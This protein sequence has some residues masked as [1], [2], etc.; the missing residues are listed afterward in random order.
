MTTTL[1]FLPSHHNYNVERVISIGLVDDHSGRTCLGRF[2]RLN[3]RMIGYIVD[4]L[5]KFGLRIFHPVKSLV[6]SI[7][8]WLISLSKICLFS[9]LAKLTKNFLK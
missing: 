9:N 2:G 5:L 4:S 8:L 1:F 6:A 7:N 3:T